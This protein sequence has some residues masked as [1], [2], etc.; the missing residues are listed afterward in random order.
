[1][2]VHMGAKFANSAD[3][4]ASNG[5]SNSTMD[6]AKEGDEKEEEKGERED[7]K[8]EEEGRVRLN[9]WSTDKHQ[10]SHW[11]SSSSTNGSTGSDTRYSTPKESDTRWKCG[12]RTCR[13]TNTGKPAT[14]VSAIFIDF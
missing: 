2:N 14:Q 13:F 8:V 11:A 12:N 4:S 1:M 7:E 5:T 3:N 10:K 9:S 6:G